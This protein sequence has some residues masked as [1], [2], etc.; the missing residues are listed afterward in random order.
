V[1]SAGHNIK[2]GSPILRRYVV[3]VARSYPA[4][5][6]GA[7]AGIMGRILINAFVR[8]S[9]PDLCYPYDT[10][11]I[12]VLILAILIGPL[13]VS[14]ISA[15]ERTRSVVFAA[16]VAVIATFFTNWDQSTMTH[17]APT[18]FG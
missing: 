14:G 11:A 13:I 18:F 9:P 4:A 15:R 1:P 12:Y 5:V 17:C 3:A 16:I 7:V 8:K 6:V 2:S 10:F